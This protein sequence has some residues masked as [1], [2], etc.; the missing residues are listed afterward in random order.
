[1]LDAQRIAAFAVEALARPAEL[2]ARDQEDI[3]IAFATV[4]DALGLIPDDPDRPRHASISL[5][6]QLG[7]SIAIAAAIRAN[8]KL[9]TPITGEQNGKQ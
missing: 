2:G 6:V 5:S 1:M 8:A 4:R 3:L 9:G 7:L